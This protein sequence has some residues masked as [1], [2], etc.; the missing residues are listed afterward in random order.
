MTD[1]ELVEF[2]HV[3]DTYLSYSAAKQLRPLVHTCSW[4]RKHT[5]RY[6]MAHYG[7][8]AALLVYLL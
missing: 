6:M 3:H 7:N 4:E 1:G 8:Y 2:Q 5:V